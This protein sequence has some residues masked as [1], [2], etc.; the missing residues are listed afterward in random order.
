[1]N[2]ID[3]IRRQLETAKELQISCE[4]TLEGREPRDVRVRDV[5]ED[6]VICDDGSSIEISQIRKVVV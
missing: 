2:A 5:R 6:I 3:A 1:M 4:I